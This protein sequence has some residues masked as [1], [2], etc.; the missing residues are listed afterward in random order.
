MIVTIV[1][2][3]G[4]AVVLLA[5][6]GMVRPTLVAAEEKAATSMDILGTAVTGACGE[7]VSLRA[8][9]DTLRAQLSAALFERNTWRERAAVAIRVCGDPVP[10]CNPE[11]AECRAARE[12]RT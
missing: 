6:Y 12:R 10:P 4:A 1:L 9:I 8:E 7:I 2:A 11:C 5:G 3:V